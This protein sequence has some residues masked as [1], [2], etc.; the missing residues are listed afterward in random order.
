LSTPN[1]HKELRIP[2]ETYAPQ[3]IDVGA[4]N[5][6]LLKYRLAAP[7]LDFVIAPFAD[8]QCAINYEIPDP[9]EA[10]KISD[11]RVVSELI[12]FMNQTQQYRS[13]DF[14]MTFRDLPLGSGKIHVNS[15]ISNDLVEYAT[16]VISAWKALRAFD[17]SGDTLVKVGQLLRQRGSLQLV[18][19]L[20]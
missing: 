7:N 19:F 12:D 17:I 15:S 20:L 8:D 6:H 4:E 18:G 1:G 10:V 13:A 11:V 2:A 5:R 9:A 14:E 3:G 16:V